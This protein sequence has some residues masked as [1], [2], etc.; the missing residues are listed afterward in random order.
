MTVGVAPPSSHTNGITK[1]GETPK[2]VGINIPD[3]LYRTQTFKID[4]GLG[5]TLPN[6]TFYCHG[7]LSV[8]KLI[9][10]P[11]QIF[12]QFRHTGRLWWFWSRK[13]NG[14]ILMGFKECV[15]G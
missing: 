12:T 5:K 15:G 7:R 14:R 9:I 13:L 11:I 8:N 2:T 6:P 3:T 1:S 4:P 10:T